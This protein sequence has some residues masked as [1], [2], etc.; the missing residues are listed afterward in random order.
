MEISTATFFTYSIGKNI[1]EI[2]GI[3]LVLEMQV[4]R[5]S[6]RFS[7][8][9]L[10]LVK[11]PNCVRLAGQAWWMALITKTRA[12]G[13][14]IVSCYLKTSVDN[15]TSALSLVIPRTIK[16]KTKRKHRALWFWSPCHISKLCWVFFEAFLCSQSLT[17]FLTSR[18][19]S[20]FSLSTHHKPFR[21]IFG[22]LSSTSIFFD[23]ADIEPE[24]YAKLLVW[25]Y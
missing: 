17:W 14:F 16:F 2:W 7:F 15:I 8:S 18:M 22:Q 20:P 1:E 3:L 24:W 11:C 5:P 10:M 21:Q 6:K 23:S 19:N 9:P 4:V 25:F 12:K 13:V